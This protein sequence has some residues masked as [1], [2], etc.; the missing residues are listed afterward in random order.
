MDGVW[1]FTITLFCTAIIGWL[2][3][4]YV[5]RKYDN[6]EEMWNGRWLF[7]D[8]RIVKESDLKAGLFAAIVMTVLFV[9]F[10]IGSL[11]LLYS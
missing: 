5:K 9:V 10:L 6:G 11:V 2:A 4:F 1:I 8:T 3:Y 7:S